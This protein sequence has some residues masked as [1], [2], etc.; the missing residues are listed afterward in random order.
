[1][2]DNSNGMCVKTKLCACA[3]GVAIGVTKG[4]SLM[5]LAWVSLVWGVGAPLVVHLAAFL[6]GYASTWVGG[7][8]GGGWGLVCGFIFGIVVG[9]IYNLCLCCC[10]KKFC[11][12]CGCSKKK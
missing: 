6:H 10:C 11:G 9:W 4:L 2:S 8:I 3:L 7:L 5:L 12:V 1:M